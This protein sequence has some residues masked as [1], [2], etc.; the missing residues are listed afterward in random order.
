M[1]KRFKN[2][3][4]QLYDYFLHNTI[5]VIFISFQNQRIGCQESLHFIVNFIFSALPKMYLIFITVIDDGIFIDQ[6]VVDVQ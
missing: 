6:N 1:F 2:L 3:F 4:L 5:F